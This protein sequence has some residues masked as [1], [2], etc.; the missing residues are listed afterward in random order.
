MRIFMSR[1]NFVFH[2]FYLAFHEHLSLLIKVCA[3]I[4]SNLITKLNVQTC[5]YIISLYYSNPLKYGMEV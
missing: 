5:I 4:K 1:P 2:I 3:T